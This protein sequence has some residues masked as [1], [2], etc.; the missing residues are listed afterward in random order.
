M[1]SNNIQS[2]GDQYIHTENADRQ[3]VLNSIFWPTSHQALDTFGISKH[4]AEDKSFKIL[5]IGCGNG[6]TTFDMARALPNAKVVG[7]DTSLEMIESAKVDLKSMPEQVQ[8][9]VQFIHQTGESAATDYA[10]TFDVVWMRF[11][12]VHVP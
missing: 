12:V 4:A 6:S 3:K 10:D 1:S 9:R 8:Q 5:E 2:G 11:V 7:L